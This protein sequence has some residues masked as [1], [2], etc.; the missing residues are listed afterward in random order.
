MPR[1]PASRITI[2]MQRY[3]LAVLLC[4]LPAALNAQGIVPAP[5]QV[6]AEAYLL[7]DAD[8]G[9]VLVESNA[10]EQLPP[11][12]LTKMMTA[13]VLA[14]EME[15]GRIDR[16]DPVTVSTNAWS[17]NPVFNGSSL[18][19]IEPGKPVN[20]GE[21]ERGIV[22]SSGNDATVAVAE[23]VAG[24]ERA[25]ADLMNRYAAELGLY[26]SYFVNS[27]GLPH[28]QHLT[29]ARDLATLAKAIIADF[30]STTASTRSASSPTTISASTTATRSSVRTP[31]SMA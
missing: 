7:I 26:G 28:P 10:D 30:P 23:H 15:A 14:A 5:P 4:L 2:A 19:W 8:T 3:L 12:S 22:I 11:A 21:L 17:Q 16:D 31:Q 9:T 6:A 24:S 25:F 27:H 29:T 20:I 18:M 1:T 13:Y